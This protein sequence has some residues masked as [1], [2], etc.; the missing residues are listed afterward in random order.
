MHGHNFELRRRT[1]QSLRAASV[2][3]AIACMLAGE[4]VAR[5]D[6]AIG[7]S[8]HFAPGAH[9][10]RT[11]KLVHFITYD[12]SKT[13]KGLAGSRADDV[14]ILEDRTRTL[15]MLDASGKIQ[16][17]AENTRRFGG[18]NPKDK[19]VK[20]RTDK[21][22][23][24][25]WPNGVTRP[26]SVALGDAGDGALDQL[27]DKP[28]AIGQ[29][30]T[31]QRPVKVDRELGQ[32]TMTYTDKLAR[33]EERGGHRIAIIEVAG[34][35]RVDAAKDL[36]AKGFHTA[37]IALKGTA[38]FDTTT[39]LPG[40]QHYTADVEWMTHVIFAK[41]GVKFHDTYDATPWTVKEK[42]T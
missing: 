22:E 6:D 20:Q 23:G 13:L 9:Y 7:I 41:V 27:P 30:W 10:Q 11:E 18:A 34:T 42:T 37:P 1:Y 40:T 4:R 31:F 8:L 35:G 3:V 38:E 12:I 25:I 33:V 26:A 36:Q 24:T 17:T 21:Y 19:S 29:T 5:A 28:L 2:A 16:V 39:G 14:T 32:G 15:S